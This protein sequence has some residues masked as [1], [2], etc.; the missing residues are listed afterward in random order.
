M[1]NITN[2]LNKRIPENI[3]K[4]RKC[5]RQADSENPKNIFLISNAYYQRQQLYIIKNN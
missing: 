4:K 2:A 5:K 1:K 3:F